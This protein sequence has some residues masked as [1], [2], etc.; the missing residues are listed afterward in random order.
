MSR[1]LAI[2]GAAFLLAGCLPPPPLL[3]TNQ[4][5]IEQTKECEAAGLRAVAVKNIYGEILR[6]QCEPKL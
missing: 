4:Q 5:V 1:W 3:P 6:V 2:L